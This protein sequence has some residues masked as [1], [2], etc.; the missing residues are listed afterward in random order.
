MSATT[1]PPIY[2]FKTYQ[3]VRTA[4][5][6]TKVHVLLRGESKPLRHVVRHSPTGFE[7]GYGGSGPSDLALSI[8]TDVFGFDPPTNIYMA[9]KFSKVALFEDEWSITEYESRAWLADWR[10]RYG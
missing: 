6:V 9:F 10:E 4:P 1:A 3:G 5:G 8:L 2:N 7:W